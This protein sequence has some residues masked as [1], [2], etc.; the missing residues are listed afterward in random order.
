MNKGRVVLIAAIVVAVVLLG[1]AISWQP[2]R[3]TSGARTGL[4][5]VVIAV[6]GLDWYLLSQYAE[7]QR[8]P[9]LRQFMKSAV[10]GEI[11]ADVPPLPEVGWTRL[12]RGRSLDGAEMSRLTG[13]GGKRLTGILPDVARIAG[14]SGAK[15]LTVGWPCSWP[16][17]SDGPV[18]TAAA[19]RPPWR[20]HELSL[21]PAFYEGAPG[22]ASTPRIAEVIDTAVATRS[23]GL[24][25]DFRDAICSESAPNELWRDNVVAAR[26][27]YLSDAVALDVAA[28]LYAEEE[29][30][31]TLV[32]LAG[33]DAVSHRFLA[34]AVPEY[35]EDPPG[36][37]EAFSDVLGSYYAF[38][39]EAVQRF[40]RLRRDD[41]LIFV[42]SANGFHPAENGGA[43][44]GSHAQGPPGVLMVF[45]DKLKGKNVAAPVA[46]VDIAPTVLAAIGVPIPNDVEGRVVP[47]CI[48]SGRLR[49]AP[50][51]YVEPPA[52]P[53]PASADADLAPMDALASQ[54]LD[55]LS[56]GFPD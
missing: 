49:R 29:P 1:L 17:E 19:A 15:T 20:H 10:L 47:E 7:E 5:V 6:D 36:E 32:H 39:D 56:A 44:S 45:S 9:M 40:H 3:R 22:Q 11:E 53:A 30:D 18:L 4:S 25:S 8:V 43:I 50:P 34:P 31:L 26:W 37:G 16:A 23:A 55:D 2:E 42:C 21:A 27:S 14:A 13:V 41:T 12:A 48:P 46:T 35:F 54:R 33:L 51:R 24:E 38:L 52:R 28:R